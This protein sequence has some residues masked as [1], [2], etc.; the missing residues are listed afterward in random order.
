MTQILE[1][2]LQMIQDSDLI[3]A[4]MLLSVYIARKLYDFLPC[5]VNYSKSRDDV[6]V[7]QEAEP[8]E[9]GLRVRLSG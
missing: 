7:G 3:L 5:S 6:D 8:R 4:F 9:C 2:F 1:D